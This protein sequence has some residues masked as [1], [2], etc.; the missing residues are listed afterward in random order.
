[1]PL[2]EALTGSD[3]LEDLPVILPAMTPL[4]EMLSDYRS[5]ALSTGRHP[6]S[7]YRSYAL[8]NNICSSRE[9]HHMDNN[10][11]VIVAGGAICRQRPETAKGFVFLTLEDESGMINIIIKPKIFDAYRSIIMKSSFLKIEGRLQLEHG[12][13][14]VIAQTFEVLPPLSDEIVIDM[15]ARNFH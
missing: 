14:N 9:L 7:F 12:V 3:E 11:Q 10:S 8:R 13:A 6:M 2:L 5:M 15:P 4:D 1:M